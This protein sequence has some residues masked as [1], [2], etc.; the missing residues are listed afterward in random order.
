[1]L[2]I[3][4]PRC[5]RDVYILD[6]PIPKGLGR[7][8]SPE[9]CS[10]SSQ[11]ASEGGATWRTSSPKTCLHTVTELSATEPS[12][13]LSWKESRFD[14][15]LSTVTK[16]ICTIADLRSAT[17]MVAAGL[18]WPTGRNGRR[19]FARQSWKV[20]SWGAE[21]PSCSLSVRPG[22]PRALSFLPS[23]SPL[24]HRPP[25]SG[26]PTPNSQISILALWL[27]A[28]GRLSPYITKVLP[29]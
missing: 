23:A 9:G 7:P 16:Q 18:R 11:A 5:T 4:F 14:G 26:W 21:A 22:P 12:P 2:R 28:P 6:L 20:T 8:G 29:L 27:S 24:G 13:D 3:C 17:E 19:T 10:C 15:L 1:M 25:K